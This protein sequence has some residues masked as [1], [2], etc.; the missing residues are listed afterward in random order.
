MNFSVAILWTTTAKEGL[1]R[2]P[3][4]VRKG[5]LDKAD[6]LLTTDPRTASKP[7]TGLL[8]GYYRI[9]YARYRAIYCVQE[10]CL[11]SGE[12]RLRLIVTFV[13]AGIRKEH[14]KQDVYRVAERLVR[15]VLTDDE[16]RKAARDQDD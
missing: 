3:K 5:L 14:D 11:A 6:E 12:L 7:L 8:Q 15:L 9:T 16:V 2:L 4:K 1:K 10:E 13:V